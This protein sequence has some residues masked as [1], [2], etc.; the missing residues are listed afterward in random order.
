MIP[1]RNIDVVR[2]LK[3]QPVDICTTAVT[4]ISPPTLKRN[5]QSSPIRCHKRTTRRENRHTMNHQSSTTKWKRNTKVSNLCL[6]CP[7]YTQVFS[8]EMLALDEHEMMTPAMVDA[9]NTSSLTLPEPIC[10][11]IGLFWKGFDDSIV[12]CTQSRYPIIPVMYSHC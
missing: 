5:E 10:R 3:T 6:S 9:S 4:K 11:E 7:H 12:W 8:G 2:R 1:R